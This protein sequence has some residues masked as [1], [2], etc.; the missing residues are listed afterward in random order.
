MDI[1][2]PVLTH[3]TDFFHYKVINVNS[4]SGQAELA[5]V[6]SD[7]IRQFQSKRN[8]QSWQLNT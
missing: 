4:C 1:C 7:D 6:E 3:L 8:R 2:S 5:T